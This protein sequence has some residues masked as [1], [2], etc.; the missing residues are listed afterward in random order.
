MYQVNVNDKKLKKLRSIDFSDLQIREAFDIEEWI[1]KDPEILKEELLIIGE[2]EHTPSGRRPDLVAL[3]KEGNLVIIELK[4]DD[5][6][7]DVH[8]QAITYAARMSELDP[9]NIVK[10]FELFLKDINENSREAKQQINEFIEVNF[11]KINN[12]QRIILVSKEFHQ[13]V[14]KASAW[15]SEE[16][17]M[18]IKCVRLLPFVN[19]DN[20]LFL[21]SEVLLPTP[22]LED[23]I[24]RKSIKKKKM[25]LSPFKS[26][27][28]NEKGTFDDDTLIKKL[29]D[30]LTRKTDQTP[31][32]IEF[33]KILLE[34]ERTYTREELKEKLFERGIGKNIG[35]TGLLLSNISSFLTKES[36]SHLRQVIDYSGGNEPGEH[37]DDYKIINKYRSLVK[38]VIEEIK[39]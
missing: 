14:L 19:D 33:I 32:L 39:K 27:F 12:K 23:Y 28:S 9:D 17:G 37:K 1:K 21:S 29:K 16:Y 3:D 18:R 26:T 15:L 25:D 24:E 36:T 11:E 4:R 6:G 20:E 35:H 2:Q 5:S 8:W 34:E 38:K 10:Q 13:D 22:G 31:R 30:T 7:R